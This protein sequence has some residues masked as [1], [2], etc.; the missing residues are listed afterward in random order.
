MIFWNAFIIST[1]KMNQQ[2]ASSQQQALYILIDKFFEATIL[3]ILNC[4]CTYL[5]E[6]EG[7]A[8]HVR[9]GF[10]RAGDAEASKEEQDDGYSSQ[11]T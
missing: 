11:T 4:Y 5:Q 7:K 1:T 3:T 6:L 8:K 2:L 9:L 10:G